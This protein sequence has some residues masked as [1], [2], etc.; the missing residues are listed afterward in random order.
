MMSLLEAK[1]F[2]LAREVVELSLV[3]LR[4]QGTRGQEGLVLWAGVQHGSIVRVESALVPPQ[5]AIRNEEGVCVVVDGQ[6]LHKVNVWL[7]EKRLTLVGQIHSHPGAAYHSATDD[8]F[9]IVTALGGVSVVL[10]EFARHGFDYASSAVYR[11]V[12]PGRWL[13]IKPHCIP[14]LLRIEDA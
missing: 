7:F 13:P 3:H 4:A 1:E 11:L 12:G 8:A 2:A 14:H 9:S 6:A 10:P 5:I